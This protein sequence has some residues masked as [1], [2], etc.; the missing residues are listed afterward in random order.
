MS[1]ACT[2][3]CCGGPQEASGGPHHS[4]QEDVAGLAATPSGSFESTEQGP[5]P[6]PSA[7]GTPAPETWQRRKWRD[8]GR[9]PLAGA[10]TI[11]V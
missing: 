1:V 11:M 2:P 8:K 9:A 6:T 10:Q 4:D 3:R 7:A 5:P